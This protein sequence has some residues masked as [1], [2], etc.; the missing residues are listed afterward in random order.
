MIVW[1]VETGQPLMRTSISGAVQELA[2]DRQTDTVFV[3]DDRR[4]VWALRGTS[5]IESR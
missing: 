2:Y 3:Q 5:Q 1:D 4:Q